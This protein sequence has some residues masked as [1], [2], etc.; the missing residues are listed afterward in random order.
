V[1]PVLLAI[2]EIHCALRIVLR[3]DAE[4]ERYADENG[5][6]VPRRDGSARIYSAAKARRMGVVV[7]VRT[8]VLMAV[9][10][11]LLSYAMV[12]TTGVT[13][14]LTFGGA[15]G[16]AI[17]LL[18]AFSTD[19]FECKYK[20]KA[21]AIQ[22]AMLLVFLLTVLSMMDGNALLAWTDIG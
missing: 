20:G 14:A 15:I 9:L 10:A 5:L 7:T 13:L 11:G 17:V 4:L 18:Q 19:K 2:F 3:T 8:G 22:M 1:A 21:G 12:N 6:I 16:I